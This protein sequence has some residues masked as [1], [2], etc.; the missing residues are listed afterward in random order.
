MRIFLSVLGVLFSS[1]IGSAEMVTLTIQPQDFPAASSASV[2]V[3]AG[4]LGDDEVTSS[5]SGQLTIDLQP[6]A[7]NPETAQVT[8]LVG[9]VDDEIDF[10]VGGGFPRPTVTVQAG[11]GE[12]SV[13][14]LDPAAPG[15]ITDGRFSQ[16]ASVIEF[17]GRVDTSVQDEPLDLASQPPTIV[18]FEDLVLQAERT[19][20]TLEGALMTSLDIPVSVGVLTLTVQL[21]VAG[22]LLASGEI[23]AANYTLAASPGETTSYAS[24]ANWLRNGVPDTN[25]V[26]VHGDA[27]RIAGGGNA[28]HVD[29]VGGDFR[30]ESIVLSGSLQVTNG[31]LQSDQVNLMPGLEL[32]IAPDAML[33]KTRDETLFAEAMQIN[34]AGFLDADVDLVASSLGGVGRVGSLRVGDQSSLLLSSEGS[35]Q[36]DRALEMTATSSVQIHVED[37]MSGAF[38]LATASNV[39]ASQLDEVKI[40]DV[41]YSLNLDSVMHLGQGQ[42]GQ[43]FLNP[44]DIQLQVTQAASGDTDGNGEIDFA[45]FLTLSQNFGMPGD[46]AAGD[47]D[48]SG[49]VEFAD[50][51]SL[52]AVF[53]QSSPSPIVTTVPEPNV[54]LVG[55][56]GLIGGCRC[57]R[58]RSE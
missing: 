12:V 55:V 39:S 18:D 40:N 42:F 29:L 54:C 1:L 7:L 33:A 3:D 36:I 17:A 24:T 22:N 15:T 14:L 50:F 25:S 49:T 11:P 41:S 47:F 28:S 26:P 58:T 6:S 21:D 35:L 30:P 27:V 56:L 2:F 19:S 52:S 57:R 48:G 38:T 53:G 23:P 45:D 44:T 32:E 51:L 10:L 4:F 34:V 43:L 8:G 31:S 5:L 20:L 37:G 16:Q 46:W 9:I 13:N